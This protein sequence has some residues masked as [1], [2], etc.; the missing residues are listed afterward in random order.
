MIQNW[1]VIMQWSVKYRPKSLKSYFGQ[2]S[3]KKIVEGLLKKEW[4]G[5]VLITGGTGAGKTTLARV[6]VRELGAENCCEEI[7]I[8]DNRG[9]DDIRALAQRA[10][11]AP[12]GSK[13]RVFVLDECQM[14]TGA[15]A[16]ALL[17]VLEEP[18]KTT[19]FILCTDQ[20]DK[21]L[22][23]ILGRCIKINLV[24]PT[25]EDMLPY[26]KA[27]A[28]REELNFKEEKLLKIAQAAGGQPRECMQLLE[29]CASNPDSKL[30]EI[31]PQVFGSGY[32]VAGNLIVACCKHNTKIILKYWSFLEDRK[33]VCKQLIWL[34]E[35]AMSKMTGAEVNNRWAWYSWEK[36][37]VYEIIQQAGLDI[38]DLVR[39][40][41]KIAD[42]LVLARETTEIEP[43]LLGAL[44]GE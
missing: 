38:K 20:P 7:N 11:L 41:Q 17:K 30:S 32:N 35:Y 34:L 13:Y 16:S 9:I 31:A 22:K 42:V 23:T 12:L 44:L 33:M 10:K 18:C 28:K 8:G 36:Q 6:I 4:P 37:K 27:V 29:L 1:E 26:L 43:K 40:Y 15:A 21:L 25:P 39:L 24:Q 14:L 19:K 2:E 3:A 5:A